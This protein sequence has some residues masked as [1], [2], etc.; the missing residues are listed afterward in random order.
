MKKLLLA[1]VLCM[2]AGLAA[3]GTDDAGNPQTETTETTRTQETTE[4][5]QTGET[6]VNPPE[7][8][9]ESDPE[10]DE[11]SLEGMLDRIYQTADLS[12]QFGEFIATGLLVT[13]ITSENAGYHLGKEDIAFESAIASEP[14]MST[15]AYSL[16]LI[17]VEE[18]TDIETVKTEIRDNVDPRKWICVG[19]DPD[20][21]IV[22]SV[23]DVIILIMSDNEGEA[24]H[25][26]FL[27]L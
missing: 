18:G 19:V 14:M 6:N 11:N 15:S 9:K 26:A 12:A 8:T 17:R 10:Y 24:L 23:G 4:N 7:E 16:C 2:L 25:R 21:V 20:N 22:D 1:L 5:P 13:P 3:C 27:A